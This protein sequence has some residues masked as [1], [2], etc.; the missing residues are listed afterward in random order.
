MN[1]GLGNPQEAAQAP[2]QP[3]SSGAD[4]FSPNVILAQKNAQ[5]TG[6]QQQ[7]EAELQNAAAQQGYAQAEQDRA[8]AAIMQSAVQQQQQG[9]VMEAAQAIASGTPPEALL[10]RG[11]PQELVMAAVQMLQQQQAQQ[12]AGLGGQLV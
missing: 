7:R 12:P 5:L 6:A 10:Q 8:K 9:M 11:A 1:P 4:M 3:Q 2:Q